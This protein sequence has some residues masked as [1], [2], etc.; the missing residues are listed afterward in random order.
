M[1]QHNTVIYADDT[2][3][4]T[5]SKNLQELVKNMKVILNTLERSC[6]GNLLFL[7]LNE[8]QCAVFQTEQSKCKICTKNIQI[9]NKIF[10]PTKTVKFSGLSSVTPLKWKVYEETL[11]KE[12]NSVIYTFNVMKHHVKEDIMRISS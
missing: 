10:E 11:N 2:N 9:E 12:L 7:N 3:V 4:N 6:S 5:S 1:T 8:T